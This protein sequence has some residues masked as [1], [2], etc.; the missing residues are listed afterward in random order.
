MTTTNTDSIGRIF[1]GSFVVR[2]S[3]G[4]LIEK[5][6]IYSRN[7]AF[8]EHAFRRIADRHSPKC[9]VKFLPGVRCVKAE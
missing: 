1:W 4:T 8:P 2:S 9:L 3:K 6:E 7:G 5:G